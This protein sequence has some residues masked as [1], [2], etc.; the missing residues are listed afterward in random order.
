MTILPEKKEMLV[1]NALLPLAQYKPVKE[2]CIFQYQYPN[3]NQDS[4]QH[5]PTMVFFSFSGSSRP[6]MKYLPE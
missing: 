3:L 6:S 2:V 1:V 5:V 4:L